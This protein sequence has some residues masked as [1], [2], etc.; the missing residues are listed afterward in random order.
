MSTNVRSSTWLIDRPISISMNQGN[1]ISIKNCLKVT[2]E[3]M[4]SIDKQ[5]YDE[6]QIN[7]HLSYNQMKKLDVFFDF[8]L[9]SK[10]DDIELLEICHLI[11]FDTN[12]IVNLLFVYKDEEKY[13]R[14][15]RRILITYYGGMNINWEEI[16]V[17]ID[18][19][20]ALDEEGDFAKTL[21][22]GKIIETV[23]KELKVFDFS[24]NEMK[25]KIIME[26]I[27]ALRK[28]EIERYVKRI[29]TEGYVS[30]ILYALENDTKLVEAIKQQSALLHAKNFITDVKMKFDNETYYIIFHYPYQTFEDDLLVKIKFGLDED[31]A[32][33][34]VGSI[35]LKDAAINKVLKNIGDQ[36]I[37]QGAVRIL[38]DKMLEAFEIKE[39][40]ENDPENMLLFLLAHLDPK[41]RQTC[42][43]IHTR[44]KGDSN[45]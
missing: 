38:F 10:N 28:N 24:S 6:R 45:E 2:A 31:K 37:K 43:F 12:Y 32:G 16:A 4:R 42:K 39:Q 29:Y 20:N 35:L 22:G 34:P 11:E 7:K 17:K 26:E 25:D 8:D 30:D 33:S 3:D 15:V 41:V 1:W 14:L 5:V 9:L 44:N 23:L 13:G 36:L 18:A 27:I 19:F 40:Y 21:L